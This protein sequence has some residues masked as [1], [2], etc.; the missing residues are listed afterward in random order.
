MFLKTREFCIAALKLGSWKKTNTVTHYKINQNIV[1]KWIAYSFLNLEYEG[2]HFKYSN[3]ILLTYKIV[4]SFV[5]THTQ[6][7]AIYNSR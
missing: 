1:W 5:L 4:H 6:N 2:S 7:N 3:T